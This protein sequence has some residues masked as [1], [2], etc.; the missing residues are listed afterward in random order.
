M[1]RARAIEAAC[2][3]G[4]CHGPTARPPLPSDLDGLKFG[5]KEHMRNIEL[6]IFGFTAS[7]RPHTM[8]SWSVA[9]PIRKWSMAMPV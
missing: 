7:G 9:I 6:W 3:P 5:G 2:V 4:Q 1:F 8:P